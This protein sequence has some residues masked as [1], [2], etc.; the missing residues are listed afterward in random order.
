[1]HSVFRILDANLNRAR[2]GLRTAEEFAR[3][4]AQDLPRA[5]AL[6]ILRHDLDTLFRAPDLRAALLAD[7]DV[8]QDVGAGLTLR[9]QNAARSAHKTAAPVTAGEIAA[10]ACKRTQEALRNLEEYLPAAAAAATVARLRAALPAPRAIAAIRYA[11][12][13]LERDLFCSVLRRQ[14]LAGRVLCLLWSP[15]LY[16]M[17]ADKALAAAAAGARD[18]RRPDGLLIQLRM[19]NIDDGPLL[20]RACATRKICERL[21]LPLIL[22]DRPQIAA[23]AGCDGVHLGQSDLPPAAARELLGPAKLIGLSTHSAAQIR[24][25]L[26]EPVDYLG[27]GPM[28]ATATKPELQPQGPA[29][30]KATQAIRRT[31]TLPVFA[32]GGITAPNLRLLKSYRIAAA[33][34]SGAVFA[35]GTPA[36]VRQA[37][38]GLLRSL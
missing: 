27:L 23:H 10:A 16:S 14:R 17:A 21:G 35:G 33:A 25:A 2:E 20:R 37:V 9:S 7:R 28:F 6:K 29:L 38:A 12:Y 22:N 1:M 8:A 32:I 31:C 11:L 5:R 3:L 4:A 13:D 15:D 18:A 19:K 36:A 34:V 26:R 30:A 24:A